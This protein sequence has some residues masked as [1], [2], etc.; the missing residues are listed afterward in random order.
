[1]RLL[2]LFDCK[3]VFASGNNNQ[4]ISTIKQSIQ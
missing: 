1:M 2:E 3:I 4:T